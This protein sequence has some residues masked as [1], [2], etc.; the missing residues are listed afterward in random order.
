[1]L[2]CGAQHEC[3]NLVDPNGNTGIRID[4]DPSLQATPIPVRNI[5]CPY[6]ETTVLMPPFW[7]H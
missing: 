5:K 7:T 6:V 3:H 1:M 4:T 2:V